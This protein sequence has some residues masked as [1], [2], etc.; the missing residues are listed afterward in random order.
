MRRKTD[1]TFA[2]IRNIKGMVV[3]A[4]QIILP[5]AAIPFECFRRNLLQYKSEFLMIIPY[6]FF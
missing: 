1:D 4:G 2:K 6:T 3:A 5:F